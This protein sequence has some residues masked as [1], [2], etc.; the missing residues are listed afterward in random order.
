[1]GIVEQL[2]DM[3][4]YVVL[5]LVVVFLVFVCFVV[6][7][8]FIFIFFVCFLFVLLSCVLLCMSRNV[9]T[10]ATF[11]YTI[12]DELDANITPSSFFQGLNSLAEATSAN[13]ISIDNLSPT[14]SQYVYLNMVIPDTNEF[15]AGT[16]RFKWF[17]NSL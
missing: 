8:V 10:N 17:F 7:Y 1:M 12:A 13:N 16:V 4:R 14:K 9:F 3:I 2:S 15:E 6:V 11:G 5:P